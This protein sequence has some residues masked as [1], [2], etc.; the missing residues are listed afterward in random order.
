MFDEDDLLKDLEKESE[1]LMETNE[2]KL[3]ENLNTNE[4]KKPKSNF[5][6]TFKYNAIPRQPFKG[7][8]EKPKREFSAV[9][10]FSV[11]DDH[12]SKFN[13]FLNNFIKYNFVARIPFDNRSNFLK[14]I[15]EIY[16]KNNGTIKYYLPWK[17]VYNGDEKHIALAYTTPESFDIANYY[18]ENFNELK[19]GIKSSL[20]S[21]VHAVLGK[22]LNN[23]VA[24]VLGY[25]RFGINKVEKIKY[26][27]NSY[28]LALMICSDLDIPFINLRDH[29]STER[30]IEI[31]KQFIDN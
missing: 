12:K 3:E 11:E 2:K 7:S 10:Y 25:D 31:M 21:T 5:K 23:P 15:R 27:D 28:S 1:Q 30:I 22:N 8:F 4:T 16:E 18:I 6:T 9:G 20:A 17:K 24:F 19:Q 26:K 14:S 13:T 29:D